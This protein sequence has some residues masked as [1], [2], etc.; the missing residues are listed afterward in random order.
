MR[1]YTDSERED[2]THALPDLETFE[3][4]A[5]EIER[6]NME[7]HELSGPGWYYW[8]CFPGCLPDS[9][10]YGPFETEEIAID[11]AREGAGVYDE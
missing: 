3:L 8:F 10:A 9:D 6:W 7:G 5:Q 4:D 1:H 2:E 11:D